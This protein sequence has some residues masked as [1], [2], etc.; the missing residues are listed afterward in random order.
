MARATTQPRNVQPRNRLI[1]KIL[2]L[3][4]RRTPMIEGKKYIIPRTMRVLLLWS[5]MMVSYIVWGRMPKAAPTHKR[6]QLTGNTP[7]PVHVG[8]HNRERRNAA[9]QALH[10]SAAWRKFSIAYRQANPLCVY[11]GIHGRVKLAKHVDHIIPHGSDEALFWMD[12]NYQSLCV[13]CHGYK[14]HEEKRPQSL[15]LFVQCKPAWAVVISGPPASG[16]TTEALSIQRERDGIIY[17]LDDIAEDIGLPRYERT[18]G[19]A[20]LALY[21]RNFRL[22]NH[23][24]THGLVLIQTN[25][26]APQRATLLSRLGASFVHMATPLSVVHDRMGARK[27]P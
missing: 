5:A 19:Q 25:V 2:A 20:R 8:K 10:H 21:H 27:A 24:D 23:P 14:R 7:K 3:P 13:S 6:P 26:T 22:M 9:S 4:L 18:W 17:D 16:K 15:P 1:T 11:C 12:G